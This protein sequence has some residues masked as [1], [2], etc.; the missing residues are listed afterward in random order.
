M[1][2]KHFVI[3]KYEPENDEK[4]L[5]EFAA[6]GEFI[7]S[8][9]EGLAYFKKGKPEKLH[10]CIEAEILRPSRKKRRFYEESGWKLVC[11]GSD[12]TIFVSDE[13]NAVPIHTDRSYKFCQNIFMF[14]CNFSS[15]PIRMYKAVQ[16]EPP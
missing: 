6:N 13:E 5:N 4:R 11:R 16:S 14:R 12:L 7:K 10:Y 9:S 3:N 1:G 2:F 15:K 8:Y